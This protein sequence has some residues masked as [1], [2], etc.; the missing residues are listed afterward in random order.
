MAHQHGIGQVVATMGTALNKSHVGQLRRFVKQVVLVFDADAGGEKGVDRALDVFVSQDL[1]LKVATLPHSLDP[2]DLLVQQGAEPF[3]AA[4]TNAVDVLEFKLNTVLNTAAAQGI[5]ARRQAVDE[6]LR[7]IALAPEMPGQAGAVKRQLLV[8]RI[9]QRLG[10]KEATIW[11]RLQELRAAKR[12]ANREPHDHSNEHDSNPEDET[13]KVKAAPLEL[14]LLR[15]L[16]ADPALVAVA[17]KQVEPREIEHPRLRLLLEALYR[18]Q[19]EGEVPDLDHAR[20]RFDNAA[21]FA[22]AL[23]LAEQGRPNKDR[24]GWLRQILAGFQER[25]ELPAKIEL[26]NQLRAVSDHATALELCRQVQGGP[27]PRMTGERPASEVQLQDGEEF[28]GCAER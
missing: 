22:K 27:R 18:L 19:A 21:L 1:D 12:P 24:Q 14:D 3:Q 13:P 20:L 8:T 9:T 4:L 26:Q 17:Q 2:C 10:L 15:V 28:A 25:R 16:L 5:E 6:L 23:E 7:V 11:A